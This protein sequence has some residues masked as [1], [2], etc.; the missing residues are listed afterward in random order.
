VAGS[1]ENQL[2]S[3]NGISQIAEIC[4]KNNW[5]P[6]M[7][8]NWAAVPDLADLLVSVASA[9]R[10]LARNGVVG[11]SQTF[12]LDYMRSGNSQ[13]GVPVIRIA[14]TLAAVASAIAGSLSTIVPL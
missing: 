3:C 5:L 2:S 6:I 9:I 11:K 12:T 7:D 1:R 4:Y 10:K 8:S 14:V 13:K